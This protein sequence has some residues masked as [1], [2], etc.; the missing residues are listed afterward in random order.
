MARTKKKKAKKAKAKAKKKASKASSKKKARKVSHA[1]ARQKGLQFEREVA[2]KLGH[3]FPEAKRH[4]EYQASEVD[5]ADIAGTGPYKIQCKN[6]QNYVSISKIREVHHKCGEIP[7][8]VT[9]GNK[10]KPMAIMPFDDWVRVLELA[11]GTADM[12]LIA[13]SKAAQIE[14]FINK[15]SLQ[16]NQMLVSDKQLEQIDYDMSQRFIEET[17]PAS[18]DID[19]FF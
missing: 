6:Y 7:V 1:G 15:P 16:P 18:K 3:I 8:L 2:N 4:L 12:P 9:K 14:A 5:G 13:D 11:H 17:L 10:L 19:D